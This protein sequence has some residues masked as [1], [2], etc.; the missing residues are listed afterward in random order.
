MSWWAVLAPLIFFHRISLSRSTS[1]Y[2]SWRASGETLGNRLTTRAACKTNATD[3]EQKHTEPLRHDALT[4][5]LTNFVESKSAREVMFLTH[6]SH[7]SQLLDSIYSSKLLPV[8]PL[9]VGDIFTPPVHELEPQLP[10]VAGVH[11]D[12]HRVL[13]RLVGN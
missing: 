9:E 13:K 5:S 4:I 10:A 1:G 3:E 12:R 11:P 7:L 2:W 6:L 8:P